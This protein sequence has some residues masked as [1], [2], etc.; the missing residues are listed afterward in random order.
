MTLT[1]NLCFIIKMQI[2]Y[3]FSFLNYTDTQDW[4]VLEF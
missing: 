2:L 4:L 3:M 1:D